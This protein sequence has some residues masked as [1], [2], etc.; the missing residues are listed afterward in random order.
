MNIYLLLSLLPALLN[1]AVILYSFYKLPKSR[2]I[3]IFV[4]FVFALFAWQIQDSIFRLGIDESDARFWDRIF[5]ISWMSVGPLS[6][7]FAANYTG[8]RLLKS[9]FAMI[10]LYAPTVVFLLVYNAL[11]APAEFTQDSNW[12]WIITPRPG[13]LDEVQRYWISMQVI[14]SLALIFRYAW[15]H[16]LDK[17]KKLQALLI[18][19]G[20]L[21]PTIQGIITQVLFPLVFLRPEVPL[22]SAFMTF[23]SV[24]T[25]I[26]LTRYHLF[27]LSESLESEKVLENITELVIVAS[28]DYKILYANPYAASV[29]GLQNGHATGTRLENLFAGAPEWQQYRSVALQPAVDIGVA[30]NHAARLADRDGKVMDV[31][32]NTRP[33]RSNNLLQGILIVG[34]DMTEQLLAMRKLDEERQRSQQEITRAVIAAQEKERQLLGAELHDNVNQLLASAMLYLKMVRN[35]TGK[36]DSFVVEGEKLIHEAIR[37]IRKLSHSIIPPALGTSSLN[38]ALDKIFEVTEK[39]GSIHIKAQLDFDETAINTDL[40]LTIYRIV[41]EQFNNIMKYAKANAVTVKIAEEGQNLLLKIRDDGV[42]FDPARVSGGVGL[43][44]I[45]TRA[46]LHNGQLQI[47]AAPGKGCELTVRFDQAFSGKN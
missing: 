39:G 7:H 2:T 32:V 18:G 14:L 42:G 40:K 27:N 4:F 8:S 10:L 20:I 26:A 37:E 44:N 17:E 31:V 28:P 36:L 33:I 45:R 25:L 12:G 30:C 46:S 23:F 21:I 29:F 5:C 9:R 1:A 15:K 38:E 43:M 35:E 19:F 34:H 22:T 41:Q 3:H 6:V 13:T 47:S 24:G 16:R 11:S